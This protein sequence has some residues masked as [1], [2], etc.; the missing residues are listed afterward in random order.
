LG[1]SLETGGESMLKNSVVMIAEKK[2][3]IATPMCGM[4]S[5]IKPIM[6]LMATATARG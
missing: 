4:M 5:T 3:V 6:P 2:L 1:K